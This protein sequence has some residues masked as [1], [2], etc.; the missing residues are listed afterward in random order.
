MWAQYGNKGTG[1]CLVF[2]RGP[3]FKTDDLLHI[4]YI[5]KNDETVKKMETLQAALKDKGIYFYFALLDKYRNFIKYDDYKTENEYRYLVVQE[6]GEQWTIN[7]DY[8]LVAPYIDRNIS[9]GNVDKKNAHKF[10]FPFMLRRAIL[11][12][13]MVNKKYNAWQ[14]NYIAS[15]KNI[16]NF[17]VELSRIDN[18]R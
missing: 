5:S 9:I 7:T 16:W 14:L 10:N 4:T 2:E 11:G 15:R 17:K 8:N 13:A 12:P 3:L 6:K 18:F 1:V